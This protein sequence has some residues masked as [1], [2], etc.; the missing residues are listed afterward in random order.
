[1]SDE[2][3]SVQSLGHSF[4]RADLSAWARHMRGN[5]GQA[6]AHAQVQQM[7][8]AQ[9][10]VAV[11]APKDEDRSAHTQP[12]PDTPFVAANDS[13]KALQGRMI[14]DETL[15]FY[16][17]SVEGVFSDS[18]AAYGDLVS[19]CDD[20]LPG[21]GAAQTGG[22]IPAAHQAV[23]ERVI[24][25]G[26]PVLTEEWLSFDGRPCCWRGRHFPVRDE[27]GNSIAVAGSYTDFTAEISVRRD[28]VL[29]RRRFNDF[30][31]ATSD[32]FW[33]TD[34]DGCL[35]LLSERFA[36]SA[37]FP[38]A[39]FYARPLA[40]LGHAECD[41]KLTERLCDAMAERK[42][43]RGVDIEIE[44]ADGTIRRCSLS[45]VPI[46]DPESGAFMGFRGAGMDI[47]EAHADTM[48]AS[49]MQR[50]LEETLEE[51]IRKNLELDIASVQAE[52]ALRAKNE[53]LAAMSHE[54]RTPLNAIIGFAESMDMA[55]FGEINDHYRSYSRDISG[56]GRHLLSLINDVL[57]VAVLESDG[58]TIHPERLSLK[59]QLHQAVSLVKM[60]AK[61]R[62]VDISGLRLTD[63]VVVMADDRRTTQ[64]LLNLMTNAIKFTPEG[65]KVGAELEIMEDMAAL[66]IWDTGIG[67]PADMQKKVFEKFQQVTDTI[68][69][70]KSEGAGLGLHISQELARLMGGDLS[71]VSADGKGSKFT[72]MLPLAKDEETERG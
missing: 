5:N 48:R 9:I 29:A 51:L 53:F 45:G 34:R 67:I 52:S 7:A 12:R 16:L 70:R 4:G 24:Q 27:D 33:E 10:A 15:P 2:K 46:F 64:I 18:N 23:V 44:A 32:W 19:R 66:T 30:A 56:A 21:P 54:L 39:L 28:A 58:V 40:E 17:V 20:R 1:M 72:V 41:P 59:D 68:Y 38:A 55:M 65:G 25:T 49:L 13:L 50:N 60:R 35:T 62:N 63:D 37:G 61:D 3:Q 11:P 43:F 26:Q 22:F 14:I 47:T 8:P 36:A 57:D 31:R 69:S 71:L 6:Q 42:A